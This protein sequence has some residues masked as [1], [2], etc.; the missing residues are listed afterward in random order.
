MRVTYCH[1]CK[2]KLWGSKPMPDQEHFTMGYCYNHGWVPDYLGLQVVYHNYIDIIIS[3]YSSFSKFLDSCF[4]L[5]VF[6][7]K[8]KK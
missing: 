6:I 3:L 7:L 8:G 5:F 1:K 2:V 4:G